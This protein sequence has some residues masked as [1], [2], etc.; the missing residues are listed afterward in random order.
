MV[1]CRTVVILPIQPSA[2]RLERSAASVFGFMASAAAFACTASRCRHVKSPVRL[3]DP[4]WHIQSPCFLSFS[5]W[6]D[7][8]GGSVDARRYPHLLSASFQRVWGKR[9]ASN[10]LFSGFSTPHTGSLTSASGLRSRTSP[11]PR[12]C[13]SFRAATSGSPYLC[14]CFHIGGF[15]IRH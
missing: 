7:N 9:A 2:L 6:L 11:A 10:R 8:R 1:C 4:M 13:P 12:V 3:L 14:V 15:F 5:V